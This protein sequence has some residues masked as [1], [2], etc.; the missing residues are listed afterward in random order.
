MRLLITGAG[1]MLGT[2]VRRAGERAG[3]QVTALARADLDIRS[4]AAV[5]AALGTHAPDVVINCAAF[6]DVDGAE[7]DPEARRINAE[8]PALV[9]EAAAASGAW[10]LHISSDYVFAGDTGTPYVE[11]DATGPL[12]AYGASKL[13][14]EL[15]VARAA[16]DAH[17]IVRSS[18]LFGS[19]GRCFPDTMLRLAAE[20]D[21]LTVVDDQV[22]CPT[23]TGH[24]ADA[25]IDL[26]ERGMRP[27]GVLHCAAAGHC[28][29]FEFAQATLEEAGVDTPVRPVSTAEFPRPARRPAHSVLRSSRADAPRLPHWRQGLSEY[30]HA[31]LVAR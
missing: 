29:W 9:A 10:T 4:A 28:S 13:D 12:S 1:G 3:H 5:R 24:L 26:A 19:A 8:A 16:P 27:S 15:G 2:D 30:L 11:S 21:E 31:R 20:R 23:F 14:G 22:G 17:T 25:L 18:W 6:T 7:T